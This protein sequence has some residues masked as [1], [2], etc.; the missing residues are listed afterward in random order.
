MLHAV[1]FARCRLHAVHSYGYAALHAARCARRHC[2][3]AL[4]GDAAMRMDGWMMAPECSPGGAH[5][6]CSAADL[7]YLFDKS[8][9]NRRHC[10]RNQPRATVSSRRKPLQESP[11]GPTGFAASGHVCM[12]GQSQQQR[13]R[14]SHCGRRPLLCGQWTNTCVHDT[15]CNMHR[16]HDGNGRGPNGRTKAAAQLI[17]EA[18]RPEAARVGRE[19]PLMSLPLDSTRCA[20]DSTEYAKS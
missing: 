2:S 1:W 20:H 8:A 7:M 14:G 4:P 15:A 3:V 10:R 17:A 18:T 9:R 12:R 16:G 13:V 5:S 11:A 19:W 6:A